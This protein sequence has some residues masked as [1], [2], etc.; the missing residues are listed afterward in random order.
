MAGNFFRA[1]CVSLF[2]LIAANH[3]NAQVPIPG[4]GRPVANA[5][6]DFEDPAWEYI[7]NNPKASNEND[8]QNRNPS[9][10]SR[11]GRFFEPA[12]RGQPDLIQRV[13][14]PEGGLPGSTGSM[15][16]ATLFS[17]VP[18]QPNYKTEQDD[19][20]A[21]MSRAGGP[22]SVS[23]SPSVVTRVYLPPFE[24]WEQRTGNSFG[25]RASCI[26][27]RSTGSGLFRSTKSEEYWPGFFLH[28]YSS[29]TDRRHKED[30][31]MVIVRANDRG[32]DVFGPRITEP[33]WWTFGMSFTPDGRVHF[34]AKPGVENLTAQDL[35]T[36]HYCYGFRCQ[37]MDTLFYDVVNHNDGKTWSTKWIVDD[38]GV[39]VAR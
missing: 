34:F 30:F 21:S 19:L 4:A 20:I 22:I 10:I 32:A 25:F 24:E 6:D 13:E 16:F 18:G 23:R 36:S 17:G 26:G 9:G 28:F 33:G 39:F 3:L 31:A 12:K 1:A 38:P 35:I 5:G 14:T 8:G 29:K 15:M 2:F 7:Y 27:S 11:N 37:R